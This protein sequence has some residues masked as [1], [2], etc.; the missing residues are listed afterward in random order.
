MKESDSSSDQSTNA[1]EHKKEKKSKKSA[2]T[3]QDEN[4]DRIS[5]GV[6][7]SESSKRHTHT[8]PETHAKD[9][10]LRKSKKKKRKENK[11]GLL[12]VRRVH[13]HPRRGLYMKRKTLYRGIR[14]TKMGIN[15]LITKRNREGRKI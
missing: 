9:R 3:S 6:K 10:S 7:N 11:E 12:A 8:E 4:Y 15:E 14:T 13:R 5:S 2:A 1:S